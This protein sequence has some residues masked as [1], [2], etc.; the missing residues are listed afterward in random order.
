MSAR[1]GRKWARLNGGKPTPSTCLFVE[2][3]LNEWLKPGQVILAS[4]PDK[5]GV[6]AEV[7]VDQEIP[8][9]LHPSPKH[10]GMLP[11]KLIT[12]V[13]RSFADYLKLSYNGI[14]QHFVGDEAIVR[15]TFQIPLDAFDGLPNVRQIRSVISHTRTLLGRGL[16]P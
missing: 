14:K 6:D 5:F 1:L 15:D 9:V 2:D 3:F 10:T 12:E 13:V 4:V 7:F 8:H 11:A 16:H